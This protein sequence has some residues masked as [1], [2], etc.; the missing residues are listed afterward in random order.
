MHSC[1]A[2][3]GSKR[4]PLGRRAIAVGITT[5]VACLTSVGGAAS[6]RAG[7][8]PT[9]PERTLCGH[10]EHVLVHRPRGRFYQVRNP[11]WLGR[12]RA[13][14]GVN[15]KRPGFEVLKTPTS[16]PDVTSYPD[17]FRG[18]IWGICTPDRRIPAEVS[19]IRQLRS[20]WA[21]REGVWGTWNASY[22]LWFSKQRM[23]KGR[24][25][26]AELMIWLNDHG[27]CC[28]L[29]TDAHKIH[30]DGHW[31]WY[32]TWRMHARH[33][34]YTAHWTYI[35]Y[36]LV[37]PRWKVRN[38]NVKAFLDHARRMHLIQRSWWLDTVGAGFEIWWGGVGLTTTNF[39]LKV[40][41]R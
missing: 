23:T 35:Q 4:A 41:T 7:Q 10:N 40:E 37:H 21:T 16:G 34:R 9:K 19:H 39:R 3:A 32:S 29:A 28:N 25:D 5:I 11:Y 20:T 2:P 26:G 27:R 13:C 18:C 24:A 6:A 14:V 12:G 8:S 33:A 22:D 1:A 17:I 30:L 31:W 38:L 15:V 36:R